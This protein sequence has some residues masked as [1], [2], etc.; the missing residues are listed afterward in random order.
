MRILRIGTPDCAKVDSAC[1]HSRKKHPTGQAWLLSSRAM[2]PEEMHHQRNHSHNQQ[3]VNQRTGNV[4][5]EKS[6]EPHYKQNNE[7]R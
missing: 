3:K 7:Q 6:Q 2:T 5:R 1:L 4:E